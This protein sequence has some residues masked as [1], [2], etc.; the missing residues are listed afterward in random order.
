[1]IP[2]LFAHKES[3][4]DKIVIYTDGSC[5]NKGDAENA[6][7]RGKGGWA[8]VLMHPDGTKQELTGKAEVSTNNRMEMQ[9]AIEGLKAVA[10]PSVI[11]LYSDSAYLV[12]CFRDKWYLKWQKN[13]WK[14]SRAEPV[15][16]KDLWEELLAL[17]QY[18]TVTFCKVKGHSNNEHN[19]RCDKLAAEARKS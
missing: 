4:M 6:A 5:W 1:M 13:G 11:E 17:Y 9:A 18:H 14:N 10:S 7:G 16:N 12:N 3:V 15:E 8:C 19:N 2:S